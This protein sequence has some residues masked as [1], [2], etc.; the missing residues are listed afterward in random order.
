ML[1]GKLQPERRLV[2]SLLPPAICLPHLLPVY[3]PPPGEVGP[4]ALRLLWSVLHRCFMIKVV[5]GLFGFAQHILINASHFDAS[6]GNKGPLTVNM[7]HSPLTEETTM[8]A[9]VRKCVRRCFI[10]R[11]SSDFYIYC[12]FSLPVLECL[13]F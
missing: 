9:H 5:T 10:P 13:P 8:K 4:R 1:R 12:L 6:K 7:S 11:C 3:R 2:Q